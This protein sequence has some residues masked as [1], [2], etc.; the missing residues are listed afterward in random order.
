MSNITKRPRQYI[1]NPQNAIVF[2]HGDTGRFKQSLDL[3]Y[4]KFCTLVQILILI[5][6]ELYVKCPPSLINLSLWVRPVDTV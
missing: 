5:C 4:I 6:V 1:N 3:L 2:Q